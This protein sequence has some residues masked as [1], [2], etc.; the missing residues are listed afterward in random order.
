MLLEPRRAAS[1]DDHE[2]SGYFTTPA[3]HDAQVMSKLN[4]SMSRIHAAKSLRTISIFTPHSASAREK[5]ERNLSSVALR[6]RK[7][8]EK[9]PP[10]PALASS[11]LAPSTS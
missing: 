4:S 10:R 8:K 1:A 9:P 5:S 11:A 6:E 2:S 7:E 3:P